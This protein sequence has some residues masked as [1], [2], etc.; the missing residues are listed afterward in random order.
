MAFN[1][2]RDSNNKLIKSL[3]NVNSSP[4][5]NQ[6]ISIGT[7]GQTSFASLTSLSLNGTSVTSSAT[8]LNTLATTEGVAEP[9]KAVILNS[10]L[11]ITGINNLSC[12]SLIINGTN[13]TADMFTSGSSD[14]STNILLTSIT[15]GIAKASKALIFGS[16]NNIS[17]INSLS[18]TK[19]NIN[20]VQIK[21]HKDKNINLNSLNK[22]QLVTNAIVTASYVISAGPSAIDTS[23]SGARWNS[24]CWSPKLMLYVAVCNG[25][26]SGVTSTNKRVMTSPDGCNW[27]LQTAASNTDYFAV[28]WSKELSLFVAVGTNVIMS[29]PNGID[30]TSRNVATQR[31]WVD[32]CWASELNIFVAISTIGIMTSSDGVNWINRA[33][34]SG[35]YLSAV[36]W[37][38][39][40]NL[41]VAVG[42]YSPAGKDLVVTSTD[43]INWINGKSN[44]SNTWRSI[45]WS[46]D[47]G[48]FVATSPGG[49]IPCMIS[50]DGFNWTIHRDILSN[51]T[52]S[53]ICWSS[54]LKLFIAI[55]SANYNN[56]VVYS[57]NGYMWY[58]SNQMNASVSY[59][60][61]IIWNS[62]YKH[63]LAVS[64][65]QQ[66]G[67]T[68][69]R[70]LISNPILNSHQT[71]MNN[72]ISLSNTNK[73]VGIDSKSYEMPLEINS[74]NGN[75]LKHYYSLNLDKFVTYDILS[76][77]QFNVTTNKY[78]NITTDNSTYGLLLNNTLIKTSANEFNTLLTNNTLGIA[79]VS[80]LLILDSSSNINGINTLYCNSAIVN[81]TALSTLSNHQYFQNTTAGSATAT[82]VIMTDGNNNVDNINQ[83][84]INNL[85]LNDSKVGISTQ[86][87][88]VNLQKIKDSV[89]YSKGGIHTALS[90]M[91]LRNVTT[92]NFQAATY[93]PELNMFVALSPYGTNCI[94]YSTN[95]IIWTD[96]V[97]SLLSSV[98]LLSIC[99]SSELGIFVACG[100][101]F[102][103][104]SLD[105]INWKISNNMPEMNSMNSICW[106]AE[107]NLFVIVSSSGSFRIAVSHDGYTWNKCSAPDS[108]EWKSVCWCNRIGLFIAGANNSN[109]NNLISSPDGI[110]WTRINLNNF[111]TVRSIE[112]SEELNMV[113]VVTGGNGPY[114]Y[115]YD[116][117]NWASQNIITGSNWTQ[118]KWLP[119]IGIFV[120]IAMYSGS[121]AY[122]YDG[123]NWTV[124][125]HSISTFYL[126]NAS[127]MWSDELSMLVVAFF[128][129]TATTNIVTSGI[130]TP[131]S[132]SCLKS[133]SNE[134]V[135]DNTNGRI[136]LGITPDYQLHLSSDSAAKPSTSTWTV[137]SDERLK[138]N[139]QNAD[140]TTCYNNIKNLRLT[141]YTWK[142]EVYSTEQVA[143]RSK[144]GWIAQEVEQIFPKAVEKVNMHGYEDCR[145]LNTDQIIAS[146]YGCTKKLMENYLND[147][148]KFNILSD[149][150]LNIETFLNS[151]PDE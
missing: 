27:T 127:F 1:K 132:R 60:S 81:G 85:I 98:G 59:Y 148:N 150:I 44:Y 94:A 116:G 147:E 109:V 75:C 40:L 43:G 86:L 45:C 18:T 70:V 21:G 97:N 106:S 73:Y 63:F 87:S 110:N 111:Y 142:D 104:V 88:T 50:S 9:L 24:V 33:H 23:I 114:L 83:L 71:P 145:T 141:K 56:Y 61:C 76:T 103:C 39:E 25:F 84:G 121:L 17:N 29:S 66:Y 7:T 92:G 93:S 138:D 151:L 118:M 115:S 14:D 108:Y 82:S 100:S 135:F 38:A 13:I 129:G 30:W 58:V 11:D 130:F 8:Q 99:W 122:S 36:C 3:V 144:L 125:T 55:N 90:S 53:C 149:K 46:P 22:T 15:P 119:Q 35:C 47:L 12:D 5:L 67:T 89:V 54:D 78:F 143:D 57:P 19:L 64:G 117:I 134:F 101:S 77:G 72:V 37:S 131:S 136:G 42:W 146:M 69:N 52:P 126:S 10:T 51:I 137:S 32:I 113:I 4:T 107:L 26:G 128:G 6:A 48:I 28:C 31:S 124:V 49:D 20:N 62:E 139:I 95:G 140:L 65:N 123:I 41:F 34:P 79:Q 112:W 80:K 102:I 2:P 105:G 133:Q 120:C 74:S 68:T 91:T 96:I 16:Y